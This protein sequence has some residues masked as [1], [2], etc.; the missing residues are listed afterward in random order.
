LV[1]WKRVVLSGT[2]LF[3]FIVFDFYVT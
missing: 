3:V 1:D 2:A